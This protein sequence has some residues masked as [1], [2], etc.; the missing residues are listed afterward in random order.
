MIRLFLDTNV[1]VYAHD[2]ASPGRQATAQALI[3]DGLTAGNAVL[4]AQVLNEFYV[5]VTR[6]IAKPLPAALARREVELLARLCVV[7][8][9]VPLVVRVIDVGAR[10]QLSHWD[11]LIIA[12]AERARCDPVLSEDLSNGQTYGPVTVRNPFA[13]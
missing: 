8:V 9:D 5:T 11:G 7:E 10:W 3:F 2:T 12:A 1:I 4:S 6:K 13:E